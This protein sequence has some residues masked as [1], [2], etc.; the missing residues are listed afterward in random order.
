MS[1]R[2]VKIAFSIIII[3]ILGFVG[4]VFG[5]VTGMNIGG[6]YFTDFVF[7]GARGYEATGIIGSFVGVTLGVLAGILISRLLLKKR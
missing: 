6:N 4:L 7:M 3:L 2:I 1:N 5:T